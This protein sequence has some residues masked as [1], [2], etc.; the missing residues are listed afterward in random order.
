MRGSI[1]KNIHL[2]I[3]TADGIPNIKANAAQMQQVIFNDYVDA[4]LAAIFIFVVLSITF[5]GLRSIWQ[6]LRNDKP[7]VAESAYTELAPGV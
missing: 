7:T 1:P 4:T 6:A 5:F 2:E 3:E